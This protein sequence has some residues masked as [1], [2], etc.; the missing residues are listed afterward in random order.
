MMWQ[1][2]S[3]TKRKFTW[4][5]MN[6][7]G[8]RYKIIDSVT[9]PI[10]GLFAEID[11]AADLEKL[12]LLSRTLDVPVRYDFKKNQAYIEVVSAET[13]RKL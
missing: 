12:I 7:H 8:S 5:S 6:Q 3:I 13:I 11:N 10:A 4:A 9:V 1:K 2:G